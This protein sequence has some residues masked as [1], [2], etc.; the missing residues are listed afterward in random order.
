MK[1]TFMHK[2]LY[3]I[4]VA[5]IALGVFIAIPAPKSYASVMQYA[6]PAAYQAQSTFTSSPSTNTN[7]N[8]GSQY[9]TPPCGS[10]D[11]DYH[12][13][14]YHQ[15]QYAP[16]APYRGPSCY[17]SCNYNFPS[18]DHYNQGQYAAP[19]PY[20][21]PSCYGSCDYDFN[22]S[23][24]CGCSYGY[25]NTYSYGNGYGSYGN[26]GSAYSYGNGYGSY[27]SNYG[28]TGY[29]DGYGNSG[30]AYSQY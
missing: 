5:L 30:Y 17:G 3:S 14:P 13:D 9:H 8:G 25:G 26:Y 4:P 16:P 6:A 11:N 12:L 21:G 7:Q 24:D 19:A 23:H 2:I 10:C 1:S 29:N 22:Y 20:R 28:Y 18:Q 15:G 27:G